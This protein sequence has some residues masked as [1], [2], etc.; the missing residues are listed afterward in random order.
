MRPSPGDSATLFLPGTVIKG[1]DGNFWVVKKNRRGTQRWV[2][3]LKCLPPNTPE[4]EK[5]QSVETI[6]FNSKMAKSTK[7]IMKNK[8]QEVR[9]IETSLINKEEV[10]RMLALAEATGMPLLLQGKPGTAKTKTV[11]E[12]AKAWLNRDKTMTMQDF[13]NK[14][15]ILETDEGTKSS[16]VK[17]MPSFSKLFQDNV[18]ELEAPITEAEIVVINEVDKASSAIRNSLLGVMNEKFLF[19]GKNKVPCKWK[20]FIA[21][22]N[23]IPKEEVGSPF[24]DRFILKMNVERIST[25]EMVK[26]YEKGGKNYK[27]SFTIGVPSKDELSNIQVAASKLE[28]YLEVAYHLSSDR[29]L[30]FVPTLVQAVAFVWDVSVDKALVKVAEI[31]IGKSAASEVGNRLISPEMKSV[32]SKID[33]MKSY[34]DTEGVSNAISELEIMITTYAAKG[35]LDEEQ[36][37]E[38]EGVIQ[39]TL[40]NHPAKTKAVEIESILEE[41]LSEAFPMDDENVNPFE[42]K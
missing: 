24:W 41:A 7:T 40:D 5:I 23:E 15:Y 1:N 6:L 28:K 32:L 33:M 2:K 3:C 38:L 13:L 17:G 25:G 35:K 19:N 8:T 10:F 14:V 9:T 42:E 29:T 37:Q 30:T 34:H 4:K 39:Y 36:V 18:Y 12:Y 31:M 22:C 11:I 26:Y 21:T 20:L 27:E 16:E